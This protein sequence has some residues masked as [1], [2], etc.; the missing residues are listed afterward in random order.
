MLRLALNR[1]LMGIAAFTLAACG[2]GGSHAPPQSPNPLPSI[3]SISPPAVI[4]GGPAFTLT[5]SGT[6]FIA[7]SSV[8]W[9]GSNRTTSYASA[10]R[11]TASI[12]AA[13]VANAGSASVTVANPA[14]GGGTSA[15]TKIT[16][17]NPIPTIAAVYPNSIDL[18]GSAFTRA[19]RSS[20]DSAWA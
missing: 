8:E 7:A 2:G 17:N 18:G 5:V 13:D 1:T 10:T 16:I 14:P 3:S 4:V 9:N 19:G 15:G 11:L 20:G 6:N 12:T